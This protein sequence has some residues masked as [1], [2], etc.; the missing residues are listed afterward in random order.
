MLPGLLAH[1]SLESLLD[2]QASE[3][4]ERPLRTRYSS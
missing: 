4:V 1:S 3:D 2:A